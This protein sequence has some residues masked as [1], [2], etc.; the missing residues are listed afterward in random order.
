MRQI[1]IVQKDKRI[2]AT[3][4]ADDTSDSKDINSELEGWLTLQNPKGKTL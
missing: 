1:V 2:E 4:Y 3:A